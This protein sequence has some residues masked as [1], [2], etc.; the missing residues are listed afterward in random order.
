M[1]APFLKE[2]WEW[3]DSDRC[4]WCA[5]GRQSREHLFKECTAW[6]REIREPWTAVGEASG[7]RD[8]ARTPFKSRKGFVYR[9]R[10]ARTRPSNTSV[11]NMLSDDYTE[12]RLA[13]IGAMRVGE[14]QGRSN[15]YI[16]VAGLGFP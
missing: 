1:I 9:A 15:F 14:V 3:T 10:Q 11:R 16:D 7:G 12:A 13:F 4:S 5:K 2:R 6:T 8:E